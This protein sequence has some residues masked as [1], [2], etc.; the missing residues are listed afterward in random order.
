MVCITLGCFL[1]STCEN[2]IWKNSSVQKVLRNLSSI[3]HCF[4]IGESI[5]YEIDQQTEHQSLWFSNQHN[6]KV[7]LISFQLRSQ[8]SSSFFISLH[9]SSR[10]GL[11]SFI[12]E[13]KA[14]QT[15]QSL[16]PIKLNFYRVTGDVPV[17]QAKHCRTR[18]ECGE[19]I[20]NEI[21]IILER[22]KIKLTAGQ[23]FGLEV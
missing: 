3:V 16:R 10:A 17:R 2:R 4:N 7:V 19:T 14:L 23:K 9:P 5:A 20:K 21:S 22:S 1:N 12:H 6:K 8:V 15:L 18:E 11:R 13:F